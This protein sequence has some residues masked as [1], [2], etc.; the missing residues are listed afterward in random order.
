MNGKGMVSSLDSILQWVT[1]IVILNLLW[2]L[3]SLFGLF[4]LGMFPATA[5]ALGISKK[6]ISGEQD[7]PLYQTFKKVYKDEFKLSNKIGWIF[8]LIGA[9]LFINYKVIVGV[10]NE[11]WVGT[12]FGFYFIVFLYSITIVWL[13]PLIIHYKN[14]WFHYLKT[15]LIIGL[16]KI[17]YTIA[18]Y[19]VGMSIIYLSLKYPG[20]IPFFSIGIFMVAW[21]WLSLQVFKNIDKKAL[22]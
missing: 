12:I 11:F 8:T 10:E 13:F 18:I 15:G 21:Y 19:L 2:F 6:W 5:A 4:L 7:I 1:R 16:V 14:Q 20:I 9:I 17:H 22:N 3:F